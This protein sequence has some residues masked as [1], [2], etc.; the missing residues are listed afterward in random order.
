MTMMTTILLSFPGPSILWLCLV[1]VTW[2]EIVFSLYLADL[3]T[4][5]HSIM[6]GSGPGELESSPTYPYYLSRALSHLAA[7]AA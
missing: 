6:R 5:V 1:S 3:L 7:L 4:S 2:S